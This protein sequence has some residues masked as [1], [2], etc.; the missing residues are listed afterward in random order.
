MLISENVVEFMCVI[1]DGLCLEC[2]RGCKAIVLAFVG[3]F[4]DCIHPS[5][6]YQFQANNS[7]WNRLEF[8]AE[9][10]LIYYP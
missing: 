7:N 10:M 5:R 8:D 2:W 9:S 6:L 4:V 1:L 3:L